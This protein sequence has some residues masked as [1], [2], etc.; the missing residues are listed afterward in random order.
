MNHCLESEIHFTRS[1]DL[2]DILTVTMSFLCNCLENKTVTYAR[3][4][5]LQESN[6]DAF[7]LEI[8]LRLG[9]VQRCVVRGRVP[10]SWSVQLAR[11][12]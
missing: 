8:S 7:I 4:V 3:V 10:A 5:G 12:N 11:L 1:D 6:L 9:E 2:S